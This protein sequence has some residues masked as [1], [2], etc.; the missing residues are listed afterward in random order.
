MAHWKNSF[1]T[2][3]SNFS[4]L[5]FF[6]SSL[7]L[8]LLRLHFFYSYLNSFLLL[9]FSTLE[10]YF[11][12]PHFLPSTLHSK[13]VSSACLRFNQIIMGLGEKKMKKERDKWK[14]KEEKKVREKEGKE[15]KRR[16]IRKNWMTD[17]FIVCYNQVCNQG[18][19]KNQW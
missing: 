7:F 6:L 15:R 14:K 1:E 8:L 10:N 12:P 19:E 9:N 13:S 2:I 16:R 18:W 5:N 3:V 4:P 17:S 11:T